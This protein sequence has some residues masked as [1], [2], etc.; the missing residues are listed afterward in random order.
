MMRMSVL[1]AAIVV[2]A[3]PVHADYLVKGQVK[4]EDIISEDENETY[5]EFNKW[6][7]L[8]YISARNYANELAGQLNTEVGKEI[9]D[10]SLYA[11]ALDYCKSNPESFWHD[12]ALHVYD[13][14][15]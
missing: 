14:L 12:S 3:Q 4:C 11:M 6:W 15:D 9:E 8:G 1:A 5:R 2:V 10:A 7:L 13:L